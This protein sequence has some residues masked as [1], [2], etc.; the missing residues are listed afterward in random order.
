[1]TTLRVHQWHRLSKSVVDVVVSPMSPSNNKNASSRIAVPVTLDSQRSFK[2]QQDRCFYWLRY[3]V[4]MHHEGITKTWLK[5]GEQ[6]TTPPYITD[7]LEQKA[8]RMLCLITNNDLYSKPSRSGYGDRMFSL[9]G[10]Q[11]WN[12]LFCIVTFKTLVNPPI[13]D[14]NLRISTFTCE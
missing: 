12:Y 7:L 11:L 10:T 9:T 1:M 13:P 14:C 8:T 2:L 4:N 3:W 5:T 6:T